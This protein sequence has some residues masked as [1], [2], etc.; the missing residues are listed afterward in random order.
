[1]N[2]S[3]AV[4]GQ[5]NTPRAF[6][7]QLNTSLAV[8]CQSNTTRAFVGQLNTPSAVVGQLNIALNVVGQLSTLSIVTHL[9]IIKRSP[10][11]VPKAGFAVV[12]KAGAKA[13]CYCSAQCGIQLLRPRRGATVAPKAGLLLLLYIIF[14]FARQHKACRLENC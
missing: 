7:G 6:V 8:V 9:W 10:S 12:L 5:L 4:V 2:N 13:G 1:M 3:C 11:V 14:V